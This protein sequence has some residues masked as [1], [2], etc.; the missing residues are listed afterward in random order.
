MKIA[1]FSTCA[2]TTPPRQYGG[3][4]LF[5]AELAKGLVAAGHEASVF[6]TGDST[7]AQGVVLR[8]HYAQ[9]IWPPDELAELRHASAAFQMVMHEQ[10][11]FDV[12]H[13]NHAAGL[14][15]AGLAGIPTLLTV[16]HCRVEPLVAHY[17]GFAGEVSLVAISERQ[18]ELSPELDMRHVV[19]HGLDPAQY[20]RGDGDG[21]YVAFLGRF[22]PEKAP[23]LAVRAAQQAGVPIRLGGTYHAVAADYHRDVLLPELAAHPGAVCVG[24]V[25]HAGKVALLAGAEALLFPIVWEEP[26]GL[27]MIEAMLMGTPV[28]AFRSGSAPE[29]VEDGITGFLVDDVAQMAA[30]IRSLGSFDRRRCRNRA[31]ARFST[32]RM[33]DDY[34]AIYAELM[35]AQPRPREVRYDVSKRAPDN[36]RVLPHTYL[37]SLEPDHATAVRREASR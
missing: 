29:V 10:P 4:E 15:C 17:R 36:G 34:L 3:T 26:F 13:L 11:R 5:V 21:G 8:H 1:L 18:A 16:H 9:P 14:P 32:R 7:P 25:G 6:A 31:R 2:L 12:V 30:R 20:P 19:H 33:V 23:H 35:R 28:I 24:E 22:A 27:V 37:T